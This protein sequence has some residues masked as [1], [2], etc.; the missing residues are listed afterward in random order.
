M[1]NSIIEFLDSKPV[2]II[3]GV[4]WII[5]SVLIPMIELILPFAPIIFSFFENISV[6]I[7]HYFNVIGIYTICLVILLLP[8]ILASIPIL[9]RVAHITYLIIPYF[10]YAE[11][12]SMHATYLSNGDVSL[13]AILIATIKVI[14]LI[15]VAGISP[16]IVE[17]IRHVN[18][19]TDLAHLYY[20]PVYIKSLIP[21]YRS[22]FLYSVSRSILPLIFLAII[23]QFIPS[24]TNIIFVF[25]ILGSIE[26][27]LIFFPSKE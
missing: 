23:P 18:Y 19:D 11:A 8:I 17:W 4:G 1:D 12:L 20:L 14:P 25:C 22:I 9:N 15:L 5:F 10:L 2:K 27:I 3:R 21:A 13:I 6:I 24:L 26:S 7:S 16:L